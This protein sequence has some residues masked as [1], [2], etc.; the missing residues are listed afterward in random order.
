[1]CGPLIVVVHEAYDSHAVC[2]LKRGIVVNLAAAGEERVK[3]RAEPKALRRSSAEG[4]GR[5][6]Y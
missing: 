3:G 2:K 5:F 1:M 6:Y 4:E